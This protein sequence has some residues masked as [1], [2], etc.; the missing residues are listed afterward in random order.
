MAKDKKSFILYTDLIH[1]VEKLVIKD[2]ENKTNYGGEL[3]LHILKYVNDLEPIAV[4]FIIEMAFEPIRLSLKRDLTKYSQ[5]IEKQR[6]NGKKGGRPKKKPNA[7]PQKP[8]ETQ[9]FLKKPKKADSV[10][11]SVNVNV[12]EIKKEK[13]NTKSFSF[14]NSLIELGANENLAKDWLKVRRDKKASNTQTAFNSFSNQVN[15]SKYNIDQ[16]LSVCVSESW[17]GFKSSWDLSTYINDKPILSNSKE[18]IILF[19]SNVNPEVKRLLK[20]E[21]LKL[22]EKNKQGGYKYEILN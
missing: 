8:K 14:Y 12:N 16:I 22:K 20:S 6:V 18:E 7:N 13:I 1:V 15:K 9:P 3:F 21:F 17:K 2:R 5:Y 10:S 4:D 19:R 11:D